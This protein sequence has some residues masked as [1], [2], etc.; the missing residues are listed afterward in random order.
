MSKEMRKK[1]CSELL[2]HTLHRADNTFVRM[3][4]IDMVKLSA[5]VHGGLKRY[6]RL[7]GSIN[8]THEKVRALSGNFV[9]HIDAIRLKLIRFLR[10][11]FVPI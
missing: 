4:N 2:L 8:E 10:M 3:E 9:A 5:Q 1:S 6:F 7:T 11:L